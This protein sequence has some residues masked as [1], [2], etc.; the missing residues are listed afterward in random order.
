MII[1][2]IVEKEKKTT[3]FSYKANNNIYQVSSE[4]ELKQ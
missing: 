3:R 2:V 4:K 1:V